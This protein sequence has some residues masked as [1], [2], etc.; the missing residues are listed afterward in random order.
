MK[1]SGLDTP[2]VFAP[3]P[4]LYVAPLA[5]GLALHFAFPARFLPASWVQLALSLPLLAVAVVLYATAIGTLR[6]A[7]TDFRFV[8]PTTAIVTQGPF[9]LSRN[10]IYLANTLVFLGVGLAANALW[11]L[12]LLPLPVALVTVGAIYPEERYLKERFGQ[13]YLAYKAKVRRWL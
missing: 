8:K 6:K 7:A 1:K 13:E 9:R 12:V 5:L 3:P 4:L 2:R 11:V 10:P